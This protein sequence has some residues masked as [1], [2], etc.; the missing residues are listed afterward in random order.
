ML[1]G[2]LFCVFSVISGF[3]CLTNAVYPDILYY[4]I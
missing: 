1:I 2:S 4:N 3:P